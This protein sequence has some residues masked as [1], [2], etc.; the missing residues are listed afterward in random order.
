MSKTFIIVLAAIAAVVL[1]VGIPNFIRARNTPSSAPCVN[2]LMQ[3]DSAKQEWALEN[4][5]TSNDVPTWGDIYPYLSSSFT[6]RWFTNGTPVCPEGG[7]YTLGRVGVHPTC[8]IGGPR[9]SYPE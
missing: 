3:I 4:G 1:A 8:T 6:N 2:R 7:T 5:K 9:H